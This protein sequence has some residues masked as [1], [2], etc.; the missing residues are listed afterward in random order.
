MG[1][2]RGNEDL[3]K[4]G[5]EYLNDLLWHIYNMLKLLTSCYINAQTGSGFFGPPCILTS[6]CCDTVLASWHISLVAAVQLVVFTF[7]L[8]L[9]EAHF[10]SVNTVSVKRIHRVS[11]KKQSK[12]FC[13]NFVIFSL[14]LTFFGTKMAKTMKLCKV[15]SLSTFSNLC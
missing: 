10:L 8:M 9:A 14:N 4:L 15:H 7:L 12:L 11:E 2:F 1:V 13:H 6:V 5:N 3:G